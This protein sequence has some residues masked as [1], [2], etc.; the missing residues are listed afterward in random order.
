MSDVHTLLQD[1]SAAGLTV[2]SGGPAPD[3]GNGKVW[4]RPEGV[5]T[6]RPDLVRRVRALKAALLTH[7][8]GEAPHAHITTTAGLTGVLEALRHADKVALDTETTGLNTHVAKVR[9]LQ[10]A[11]GP[12]VTP[13]T[14]VLDLFHIPRDALMPLWEVLSGKTLIL[15]NAMFDGVLLWRLGFRPGRVCDLMLMSKLLTAGVHDGNRLEDLAPRYLGRTMDKGEQTSDWAAATLKPA[16]LHYAALDAR[17]TYD[18]HAHLL[19]AIEEAGLTEVA[20]VENAAA[21]AFCWMA[22]TGA[23]FSAGAWSALAAGSESRVANLE[24]RLNAAAPPRDGPTVPGLKKVFDPAAP[25]NWNASWQVAH[26]LRLAGAGELPRTENGTPQTAEEVLTAVKHPLAALL[27][28]RNKAADFVKRFGRG[29]LRAWR[30]GRIY[31]SW[32]QLGAATGRTACGDGKLGLP[33]LQGVLKATKDPRYRQC[34]AAPP[35]RVLVKADYG[36]LQLRLAARLV[37]ES[38]MLDALARGEDLHAKTA[39]VITC[40]AEVTK[41]ERDMAKCLNF[42]L[43]FGMR[44]PTLRDYAKSEYDVT[45]TLDQAERYR[46]AWFQTYPA[47]ARW[48]NDTEAHRNNVRMGWHKG[49]DESRTALGRRRLFDK[50]TPT[51]ERLPS[52]VQGAEADGAKR[53]MTLL[54]ERRDQCPGAVPVLFCHD[55]VVVECDADQT[56]AVA[57]WLKQAMIDGMTPLLDPVPVDVEVKTGRTWAG[58][59]P[60]GVELPPDPPPEPALDGEVTAGRQEPGPEPDLTVEVPAAPPPP[61]VGAAPA[62]AAPVAVPQAAVPAVPIIP[63]PRRRTRRERQTTWKPL[64]GPL[65]Y[66]GGKGTNH[67]KAAKWIVSYFK[68]HRNYVEPFAG[69]LSVLLARDPNDRRLWAP[70]PKEGDRGTAEIVNDLHG[71]LTNFWMVLED[72]TLFAEFSRRVEAVNF[73][74]ARWVKA[75]EHDYRASYPEPDVTD[76]VEYFIQVRMSNAGDGEGFASVSTSR[77][78][79]GIQEQ[80]SAWQTTVAGLPAVHARLRNVL[81]LN[82]DAFRVIRDYDGE[83]TLFYLDPPYHPLT[84]VG[85]GYEHEMS[86]EQHVELLALVKTLQGKVLLSGYRQT[87][88]G[89]PFTL[90]DDTLTGWP[91]VTLATRASSGH[92]KTHGKRTEVLWTN[93]PLAQVTPADPTP[94]AREVIEL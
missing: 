65:K 68:P 26:A 22:A 10:L 5:L 73:C 72:P 81:V 4:L 70:M 9:L 43:L 53:A 80:V 59:L 23:P 15:H 2:R 85:G 61:A 92:G 3:N 32:K 34:F 40:K 39:R 54:W 12:E 24:A 19:R 62:P 94:E 83:G 67:G 84:R 87:P 42:G 33:P 35:G 11:V 50:D 29:W 79:R 30:G 31:S 91:N 21:P 38:A 6:H 28:E 77:A 48:H 64:A 82:R 69:G 47:F 36:Q 66:F 46:A 78:R 56:E 45:L 93:Y 1:L 41:A 63:T 89:R 86:H 71:A 8:D 90:Y 51:T 14:Y 37:G 17:T 58:D 20:A 55:E 76:A 44:A 13:L 52:P 88:D 74:E 57:A 75:Q 18:L 60:E 27:V 49:P 16:Q 25:W 7:L